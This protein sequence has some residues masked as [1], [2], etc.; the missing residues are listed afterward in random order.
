MGRFKA[1]ST[2]FRCIGDL[3]IVFYSPKEIYLGFDDNWAVFHRWGAPRGSYGGGWQQFRHLL[4]YE[5]AL[6]ATH[7]FELADEFRIPYVSARAAPDLRGRT[8]EEVNSS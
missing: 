3:T 5:K 4:Y 2:K 1:E 8:T 7:V 6:T